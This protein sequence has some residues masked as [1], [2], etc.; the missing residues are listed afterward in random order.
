MIEYAEV[1]ESIQG[2]GPMQG[3][4]A[5]FIRLAGCNLKCD[6]CDTPQAQLSLGLTEM[7]S[8]ELAMLM[9]DRINKRSDVEHPFVFTGG[10]PLLQQR[11]IYKALRYLSMDA[12]LGGTANVWF[13]TNGTVKPHH[14]ILSMRPRFVVSPKNGHV[15]LDVLRRFPSA[16]TYLKFVMK[17][18]GVTDWS[19]KLMEVMEIYN[20]MSLP[21]D[22]V[23]MMP[24]A[25][26]REEMLSAGPK[27]WQWCLGNGFNYSSRLHVML[28]D[29]MKGV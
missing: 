7:S 27:V 26:T 14:E 18:T 3:H 12:V 24:Q 9:M 29:E 28:F 6:F 23:Y 15:H 1:F 19:W 8:T 5:T 16:R 2:E 4:P 25:K 21:K 11:G 10:E 20:G 17:D 22:H 13:E